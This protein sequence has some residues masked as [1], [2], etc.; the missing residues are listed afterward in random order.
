M[1]RD[2][3]EFI[4]RLEAAGLTVEPTP[5][6]YRVLREASRCARRTACRSRCR[7]RPTRSAGAEP[8]S[9]NCANSASACSTMGQK[10]RSPPTFRSPG[11]DS[12]TFSP[13][14]CTCQ[15]TA[16][17]GPAVTARMR[18]G[19][20]SASMPTRMALSGTTSIDLYWLRWAQVV[21]PS[22][23][24]GASSNGSRRGSHTVIAATSTTRRS[25]CRSR[26]G[27]S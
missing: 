15:A 7:S 8:Q 6:H 23:G 3:R 5:G 22:A 16:A 9:S 27:G 4:R 1:R 19:T 24:T 26:R 21:T 25:R 11:F 2:V 20:R 17:A 14:P 12:D 13:A 18:A 10:C